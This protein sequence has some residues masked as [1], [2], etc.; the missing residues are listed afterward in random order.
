MALFIVHHE[1]APDTCPARDPDKAMELLN[2]LSRPSAARCGVQI[3]AEAV[4]QGSHSL[5]LIAEAADEAVLDAYLAPFREAGQVKVTVATS[6]AAVVS[7]GACDASPMDMLLDPADACQDALEAGLLIHRVHPLNG[8]T[9]VPDLAGGA[10]MPNGRFYLR[11]HFD[12]PN[13]DG[14]A[15]RLSVGGMVE[16]PLS[17][18]MRE[19]HNLRAE[20]RVV[21]LECAGNGRSFFDPAVP[22]E[23]WGVGA[24]STAEWTG[25]PLMEVLERAGLRSGATE[26]IF[27]GAD[28][29]LVDGHDTPIRFERGLSLDQ[30]RETGALLAYE[31]NGEP[32]SSPH[33]YPLRLIVPGWYAVTSVKWLTEIVVTDQP[34]EAYYQAEKYWFHWARNGRDERAP[35]ELMNVR[36][37]I[38]SPDEGER[39]P[40]GETA[41]RGVAWSGVGCISRVDVSLNGGSWREARLIGEQRPSSWQW[42]E[43][44]TRLDET[45]PLMVRARA[46]DM[47]GR[48]QP[49]RAEWN[50]L[51]YG[52]N[53]IHSVLA[54]VI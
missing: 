50:R 47:A 6:W 43:L 36:A 26:L 44:I 30:V 29:G 23:P 32:L 40:L 35:V 15:Y 51:G 9:S 31:M 12:I 4:A 52:N 46:T 45:G 25:V 17:L 53:S 16:R 1:Y 24:V 7:G 21:T 41:I 48:T 49:E 13:L 10:V 19:L 42:W 54:H 22:G 14:D 27:R 5:I 20:S 8:E 11:N 33:G 34:C 2:H 38:S 39:L 37:L 18:C 3:K 28:S